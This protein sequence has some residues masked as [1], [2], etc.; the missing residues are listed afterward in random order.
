MRRPLTLSQH[1]RKDVYFVHR[2]PTLAKL[3]ECSFS[4]IFLPLINMVEPLRSLI[5]FF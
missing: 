4:D 2:N 3:L 1:I 5:S